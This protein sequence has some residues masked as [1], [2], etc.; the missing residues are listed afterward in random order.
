M[1]DQLRATGMSYSSLLSKWPPELAPH[2][3]REMTAK[4]T[5]Y[6]VSHGLQYLPPA[7][8]AVTSST[9]ATA[10]HAPITLFPSPFPRKLFEHARKLQRIYNVLYARIS[11]DNRFLDNIV[12]EIGDTDD[13]IGRLWSLVDKDIIMVGDFFLGGSRRAWLVFRH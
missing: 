9:P 6:A 10:V 8:T 12:S 11:M 3:L 2:E 7:T 13:F 4:A 1:P 5:T